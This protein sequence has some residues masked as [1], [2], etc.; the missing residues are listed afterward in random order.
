MAKGYVQQHDVNYDEMFT[1]VARLNLVCLLIALAAHEGWQV[2]MDVKTTFLNGDLQEKV[3]M[4]QPIGF[5][6]T[7]NEHKEGVV[8]VALN[9]MTLEREVGRHSDDAW[10]REEPIGAHHLH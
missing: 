7:I 8:R 3:Y 6:I 5:G 10:L 2:H 4:E 9:I 1:S